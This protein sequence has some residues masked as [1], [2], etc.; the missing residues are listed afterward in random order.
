MKRCLRC[1]KWFVPQSNAHKYCGVNC[2]VAAW[3]ERRPQR[4]PRLC[5]WCGKR[6]R[7]D[8]YAFCSERCYEAHA[9]MKA[10]TAVDVLVVN[11]FSRDDAIVTLER[12][13]DTVYETLYQWGYQ[14]DE[15]GWHK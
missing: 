10:A 1:G 13:P 6:I 2:R 7:Y 11:G 8:G 12:S 5:A 4:A 15:R 14:F 3:R 9:T